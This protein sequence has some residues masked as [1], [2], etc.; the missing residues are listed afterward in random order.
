MVLPIGTPEQR[1]YNA[2]HAAPMNSHQKESMI[3]QIKRSEQ[4]TTL[5]HQPKGKFWLLSEDGC[6]DVLS[7]RDISP[8]GISLQVDRFIDKV[9]N[10]RVKYQNEVVDM[11]VNGIVVWNTGTSA[12]RQD[13]EQSCTVGINLLGPN[14]LYTFM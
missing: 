3:S 13:N 8:A 12:T 1:P 11:L 4:R 14:L 5:K 9:S 2:P 10:V 6:A 7:V